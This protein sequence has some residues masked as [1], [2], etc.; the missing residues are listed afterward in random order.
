MIAVGSLD[1]PK[2]HSTDSIWA[3]GMS[4]DLIAEKAEY[5]RFNMR[6]TSVGLV[7]TMGYGSAKINVSL[8]DDGVAANSGS[9]IA[10]N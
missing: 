5:Y 6:E 4:K 7:Q 10:T 3:L 9:A 2:F 1:F 8:I